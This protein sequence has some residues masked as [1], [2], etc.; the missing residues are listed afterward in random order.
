MRA[1]IGFGG[2]WLWGPSREK[3]G[4]AEMLVRTSVSQTQPNS[5]GTDLINDDSWMPRK[6]APGSM[7]LPLALLKPNTTRLRPRH[8]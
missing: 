8:I 4:S 5:A 6:L 2:V 3:T 1:G 7:P